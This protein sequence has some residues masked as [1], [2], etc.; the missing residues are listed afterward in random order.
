M[1]C[2]TAKWSDAQTSNPRRR[3]EISA[4]RCKRHIVEGESRSDITKYCQHQ[5]Q[6][7]NSHKPKIPGAAQEENVP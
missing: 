7:V 4:V 5:L 6:A 2:E 1:H 3:A